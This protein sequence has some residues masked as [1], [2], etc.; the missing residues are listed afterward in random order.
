MGTLQAGYLR[1]F[2][3]RR[4]VHAGMGGSVSA[5]FVPAAIQPN[6][7]GVGLGFGV[8]ATVRPAAQ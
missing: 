5:A 1:Q 6:Y 4:G 7:G 8:F 2:I 3:P